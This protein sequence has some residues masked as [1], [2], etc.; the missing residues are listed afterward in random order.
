MKTIIVCCDGTWNRADQQVE[1]KPCPTN[2]IKVAYRLK[3]RR[4]DGRQQLVYYDQG[5]GT[6]NWLD[7]YIGGA[8]GAGLEGNIHDAYISLIANYEVGDELYFFGFSRGAFTVRSLVG[9]IRKCGILRRTSVAQYRATIELYR[10][11]TVRPDDPKA[12]EFRGKHS[13]LE[14]RTVPVQMVGVW[15]TV[16]ALGVPLRGIRAI[17]REDYQFHD[18]ELSGSV[19]F[20]FH[21][22]AIDE[23]RAPF[24][25]TLWMY[26]PKPGQTIEQRWF[27]GVHSDIGGGY[28]ETP[29]S[30]LALEWMIDRATT[31]G[32]EFDDGVRA[33][34][35]THGDPAGG[36]HDSMSAMYRLQRALSRPV[37]LQKAPQVGEDPTQS[38]DDS[39][40]RRWDSEP[41]YRPQNLRDWFA[42]KDDPRAK[43]T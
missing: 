13:V 34:H 21:A 23:R 37:G 36:M 11:R 27:P 38:V 17:N 4:E 40:I 24:E 7:K 22:L 12:V 35:P 25:P 19:R 33:A 20:A 28:P 15:D 6:G 5:V 16:G 10:S 41:K 9:M 43:Q 1:G 8:T 31:A 30:D 32:L 14:E 39:A 2:V 29:L 42:R 26:K 18:T 3:K